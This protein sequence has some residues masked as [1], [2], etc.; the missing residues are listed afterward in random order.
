ML[1]IK[2]Q[3]F[4]NNKIKYKYETVFKTLSGTRPEFPQD[5]LQAF[6]QTAPFVSCMWGSRLFLLMHLS[7]SAFLSCL[8][9]SFCSVQNFL[10]T[11]PRFRPFR[12]S[13]FLNPELQDLGSLTKGLKNF[14]QRAGH[15]DGR[16]YDKLFY[17]CRVLYQVCLCKYQ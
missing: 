5:V 11:C 1:I 14:G 4:I 7:Y 6:E 2:S 17:L 8:N 15:E 16:D 13:G 10:H 3:M 9:L 12:S